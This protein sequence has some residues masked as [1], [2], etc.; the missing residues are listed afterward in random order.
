VDERPQIL[1]LTFGVILITL[2]GQ[3]L[4]LAPLLRALRLPGPN[5][6]SPDEAQVRLESAQAA[7]D[8]LE[9]LEDAGASAEP[10]RRLRELYRQRFA[11]CVA[12]L[13]GGDLPDDRRDELRGYGAMRRELIAVERAT[14]L[15]MRNDGMVSADVIRA[16][17][18]DLDLEEARIRS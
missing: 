15:R 8:R 13:G 2:L 1:L 14:L 7:L 12:L 9:E 3:G 5:Q 11:I 10:L 6:W 16:V 18:R 17:E 4:T